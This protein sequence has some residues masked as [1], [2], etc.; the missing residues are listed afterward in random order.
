MFE[1]LNHLKGNKDITVDD[2]IKTKINIVI[3]TGF[4]G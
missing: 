1:R 3:N 4:Q 2:V